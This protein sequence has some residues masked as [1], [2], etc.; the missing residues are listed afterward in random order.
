M[1]VPAALRSDAA[2]LG[3]VSTTRWAILGPGT[4]GACFARSLAGSGRGS[5]HAVGSRDP[6]R[7]ATFAAA[8]GAEVSGRYAD[9]LG[10]DD[11]DAVYV[12]TV[13]TTHADLAIAALDAGLAVLC[14]KPVTPDPDR[15]QAV[16]AAARRAGRPFLEAYKYRFGPLAQTLRQL[17]TDGTIGTPLHVDAAYGG[18]ADRGTVRLFDPALAGGAIL[19]VG[20]YPVSLAV[21]VA[22][23]AGLLTPDVRGRLVSAT[24]AVGE[25]GVDEW[26]SA[27]FDLGGLVAT[28]HTS[29]V[30]NQHRGVVVHGSAGTLELTNPWGSRTASGQQLILHGH[31]DPRTI[32]VDAVDPMAAEADAISEALARGRSEVPE[33]TWLET[34]V[35]ADHL[36]TWRAAIDP[37]QTDGEPGRPG[38]PD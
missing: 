30:A 22:A 1:L 7:A 15:T 27:T 10:R 18:V 16:L 23:W 6:A 25:T 20:G 21:G 13:H 28:T 8:Y 5:L 4:I 12:A 14:E 11:I 31:G 17:V 19:D 32:T 35:V 2:N 34:S 29:I 36:A 37:A 9:V 38:H 33:M 3:Q 26:A 24:G